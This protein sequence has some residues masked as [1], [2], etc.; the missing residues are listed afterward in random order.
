[1][2][3]NMS[4]RHWIAL[5]G[6]V[7]VVVGVFAGAVIAS[8]LQGSGVS[9]GLETAIRTEPLLKV[10]DIPAAGGLAKRGVFVQPTTAG[11]LCLWDAPSATSLARQGGCNQAD[12]PFGGRQLFLSLAYDGGPEAR[13]VKDARLIG[14]VAPMVADAQVLMSDG[15]RRTVPLQTESV[16]GDTY[17]AFGYR[18]KSADLRN[19][20]TPSAV[21]ALNSN[22]AEIDRQATG[23]GR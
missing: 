11:F 5:A 8:Q 4:W 2:R 3:R 18:F 20:V 12:D 22:G 19:G 17:R 7:V 14:L 15:S 16:G 1:M 13:D 9:P 10:L 6:G 23:F 21:I